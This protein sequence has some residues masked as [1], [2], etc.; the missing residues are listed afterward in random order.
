VLIL[1]GVRV[2]PDPYLKQTAKL[3]LLMLH[4]VFLLPHFAGKSAAGGSQMPQEP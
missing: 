3:Q 4:I 1:P 2:W